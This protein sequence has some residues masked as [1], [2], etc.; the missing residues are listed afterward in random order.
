[1]KTACHL[2]NTENSIDI[3][4][5]KNKIREVINNLYV[6]GSDTHHVP[7]GKYMNQTIKEKKWP[8]S[9]E[10]YLKKINATLRTSF[11]K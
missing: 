9:S 5:L 10:N 11:N 3:E 7:S 2:V 1:L 6:F 4:E 8:S